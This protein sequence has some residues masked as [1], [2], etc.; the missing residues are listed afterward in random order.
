MGW[1]L[2]FAA[3][4]WIAPL[5]MIVFRHKYPLWCFHT[6]LELYRF[7]AR[8]FVYLMLLRDEYPSLDEQQ[9]VSLQIEFPDAKGQL[10]Q[11]SAHHQVAVGDSASDRPD[12]TLD[13]GMIVTIIAWFT[14]L[15]V[16]SGIQEDCSHSSKG[17]FV[18]RIESIAMPSCLPPIDIRRPFRSVRASCNRNGPDLLYGRFASNCM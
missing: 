17:R 6:F 9:A 14:I 12:H 4:F 7:N 10:E 3:M 15:I 11:V 16:G 8:V 1:L 18:G 5:L 13:R 2:P